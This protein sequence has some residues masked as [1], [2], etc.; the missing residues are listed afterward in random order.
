MKINK[1]KCSAQFVFDSPQHM[2]KC[3]IE[4]SISTKYTW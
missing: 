4:I 3:D 1:K 2:L